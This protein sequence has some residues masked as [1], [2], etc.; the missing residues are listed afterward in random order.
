[1]RVGF[2]AHLLSFGESYR[3]AGISRYIDRTL[4]ALA[5]FGQ[6]NRFVAFVGPDAR[7]DAAALKWPHIV[8]SPLPTDRPLVRIAWEQV[9]LPTELRRLR[10]DV[11]HCPAYVSPIA[12]SV[13]TVVTFHDLSYFELPEAFNRSNRFYLQTFSR[14]SARRAQRLIA[15]SES[16]RRDLV[17]RLKIDPAR[18]DVVYNGVDERFKP[19]DPDVVDRFRQAHRLPERFVF[20]LGTIEP[21]KNV[22]ALLEA[23]AL[24]HRRGIKEPLLIAGGQGWGNLRL[25]ELVE[26]LGIASAV[27]WVGYANPEDQA[28][29]YNAATL[30][31]Y[32]SLYEGFGLPVLEAMACG[33]PVVASNRSSLPEVVGQ[34]GLLV[35]PTDVEAMADAL[36]SLLNDDDRRAELATL[37]L[38]Q[39]GRFTWEHA[40]KATMATYRLAL[41]RT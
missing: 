18:V 13:P 16:T 1:V 3:G 23:Y 8:R 31:A 12:S 20:Y 7:L 24:A 26:N 30:F 21:R 33:T 28:L 32:P 6:E 37:G 9:V 38:A 27:Q 11:L 34:A 22:G 15:V 10:L 19:A 5:P 39:A 41:G 2:N 17:R 14:I 25:G 29:W 40:A 4:Q 36:Y 35:D